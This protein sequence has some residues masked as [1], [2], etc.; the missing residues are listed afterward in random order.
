MKYNPDNHTLSSVK[1]LIYYQ[2]ADQ[3]YDQIHEQVQ[4]NITLLI[5]HELRSNLRNQIFMFAFYVRGNIS[6]TW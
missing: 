3:L 2:I 1:Q 5:S 4:Q 6:T